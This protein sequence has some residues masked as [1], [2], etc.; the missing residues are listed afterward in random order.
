MRDG[1]V[2]LSGSRSYERY[3]GAGKTAVSWSYHFGHWYMYSQS[4]GRVDE[5]ESL[6]FRATGNAETGFSYPFL[7]TF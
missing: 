3:E 2:P 6:L 1:F 5:V 7:L 4:H